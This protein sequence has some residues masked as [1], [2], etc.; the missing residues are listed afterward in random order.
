MK[1]D[2][3]LTY[4]GIVS[5]ELKSLEDC[6]KQGREGA[7]AA[8]IEIFPEFREAMKDIKPGAELIILTWFHK[9]D[10][11]TLS[12]H[13]RGNPKNPITGV[14]S[15]RS[16]NRPNPIGHHLVTVNDTDGRGITVEPLEA[17]DQ[18]PVVDIKIRLPK[19]R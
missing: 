1:Q 4:I 6:P 7:P 5:S 11:A 13:P 14:F 15:T 3:G 12:V 16:P 10:R 9:A 2:A 17:L 8:R 18:T 19:D